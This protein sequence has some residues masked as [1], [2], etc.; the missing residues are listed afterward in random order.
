MN[1]YKK[2]DLE[3]HL[4]FA[5]KL[6]LAAG[7]I[8]QDH[9]NWNKEI[10][11]NF[12]YINEY[13][14]DLIE[15]Y[16]EKNIKKNYP[17]H[18]LFKSMEENNHNEYEWICD[19]VDGAYSYSKGHKI[20]VTS[21]ALTHMYS[22]YLGGGF[23]INNEK[24]LKVSMQSYHRSLVD[25]EWWKNANYDVDT[26]MHNFSVNKNVYVLHIG[27]IIH[28]ACLVAS[29]IFSAAVLG[30]F[31]SGKNHE[32]AAISLIIHESGCILTDLN[33]KDI[34]NTGDI[35]GLVFANGSIHETLINDYAEFVRKQ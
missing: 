2:S 35:E 32:I 10:P 13:V 33:G 8:M 14:A 21:V 4:N 6:A 12:K 26:W 29:G 28:A 30:K 24:Q 11:N 1:T 9:D 34:T 5:K 17:N 27:S 25:V 20:S 16:I 31:M 22:A 3:T 23:F 7:K 19:Y 15:R 18:S